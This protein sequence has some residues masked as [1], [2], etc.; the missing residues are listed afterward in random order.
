MD[1][2]E[3]R[4]AAWGFALAEVDRGVREETGE[5]AGE[6][7][8]QYRLNADPPI[9]VPVSWCALTVQYVTDQVCRAAGAHNPLDEVKQ[10]ALVQSYYMWATESGRL[11]SR[12][13]AAPGDLILFWNLGKS[14]VP[15][16]D[17]MGMVGARE[18]EAQRLVTLEGN[19]SP[20]RS[21]GASQ[22][23]GD[24]FYR[25]VRDLERYRTCFAR[26]I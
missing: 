7:I 2:R 20:P 4:A 11:I 3:L 18:D 19:T 26:W 25:K 15:R 9:L 12:E 17:H 10:E 6:R 24:G 23:E 16:W 21:L 13:L 14:Q 5:N 22:R 1:G 8:D